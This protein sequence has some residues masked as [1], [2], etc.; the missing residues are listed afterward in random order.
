MKQYVVFPW[1]VMLVFGLLA[2]SDVSLGYAASSN[3]LASKTSR[4]SVPLPSLSLYGEGALQVTSLLQKASKHNPTLVRL[5]Q[6]VNVYKQKEKQEGAWPDLQ[7][8][9]QM[10]NFPLP[11]LNP[12]LSAMSGIHYTLSQRFPIVRRLGLQRKMVSLTTAMLKEDVKEKIV[13]V[14]FRV[15]EIVLQLSYYREVLR[16]DKELY[17]FAGQVA[18]VARSKYAVGKARQ[19]AYLQAWTLQAQIRNRMFGV[20]AKERVLRH[21]L[22]RL[23]G[24]STMIKGQASLWPKPSLS[25]DLSHLLKRAL[26]ARGIFLRWKVAAQ[27]SRTLLALARVKYWPDVTLQ[28]GVRQRFPNP[29]DQGN[30]FLTLGVKVALPTGGNSARYGLLQ[31]AMARHQLAVRRQRETKRQIQESL[32]VEVT[33]VRQYSKQILLFQSQVVPL[34]LQTYQSTLASYQVDRVD[35]FTL[36]SNLQT[37]YKVKLRWASLRVQRSIAIARIRAISGAF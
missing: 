7:V 11:T 1:F 26:Q 21:R 29:L 12:T 14:R 28:L 36:L 3:R 10:S 32:Q 30:P 25:F 37:L 35:F 4:K 34:A 8:G 16:T 5:R 18:A 27:Q 33:K 6:L 17:A 23:I 9:V 19:Q 31:E 22:A 24:S 13:W 20:L 15:R 2:A